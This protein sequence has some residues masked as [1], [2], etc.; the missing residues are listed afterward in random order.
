LKEGVVSKGLKKEVDELYTLGRKAIK[1]GKMLEALSLF[2]RALNIEPQNP[3][4]RSYVGLCIAHERGKISEGIRLCEE[5]LKADPLSVEN[6]FNLG[7]VFIKANLK[8]KAIEVY[9]RGL[10]IDDRN[11]LLIAELQSLGLR[12]KPVIPWLPRKNFL[13]K[14]LGI[15]FSRLGLR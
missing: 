7:K 9:R 14:Y 15:I 4:I 12:K 13:N 8:Q 2:E 1:E 5:A 3:K 11:P 10:K 6:Y